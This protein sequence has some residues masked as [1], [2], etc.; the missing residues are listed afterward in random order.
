MR[1]ASGGEDW[2]FQEC[3]A[4]DP[5]YAK[6]DSEK[7]FILWEAKGSSI[8]ISSIANLE[9]D[10]PWV[11][12]TFIINAGS[13]QVR[14][15]FNPFDV[16]GLTINLTWQSAAELEAPQEIE[17][18]AP[19]GDG[20][21]YRIPR[22]STASRSSLAFIPQNLAPFE[23]QPQ[24]TKFEQ[25]RKKDESASD[26]P[27][28]AVEVAQEEW[29]Q[30]NHRRFYTTIGKDLG[31]FCS[32]GGGTLQNPGPLNAQKG[33]L[34]SVKTGVTHVGSRN[35]IFAG[36]QYL[37]ANST[38]AMLRSQVVREIEAKRTFA[39]R[40]HTF[41]T[42][43]EILTVTAKCKSEKGVIRDGFQVR[44]ITG[45]RSDCSYLPAHAIPYSDNVFFKLSQS[46]GGF[47]VNPDV[48]FWR[49]HF[50]IPCGRAKARMLLEFGLIHSSA[51]AQNFIVALQRYG[52]LAGFILRDIG[53]TYWH[54]EMIGHLWGKNHPSAVA[55]AGESG[56]KIQH[57][58]HQTSSSDYPAPHMA[59]LASYSVLTHG[60]AEK[61]I[62]NRNWTYQAV[63]EFG[64]G[65]LDGFR[66][67]CVESFQGCPTPFV[68]RAKDWRTIQNAEILELGKKMA[69]PTKPF[70]T[71]HD[72]ERLLERQ[73]TSAAYVRA[74]SPELLKSQGDKLKAI[75]V[76]LNAEEVLLCAELEAYVASFMPGKLGKTLVL[77]LVCPPEED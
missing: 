50:S 31:A 59:R 38:M 57:T 6:P 61:M 5:S 46:G 62:E 65:I 44:D 37:E 53:D 45:M 55:C 35:Q 64:Q 41:L 13:K 21:L 71:R 14:F 58:L 10:H 36:K 2:C 8:E 1:K 9:R 47:S 34:Y 11:W 48:E 22:W 66:Q 69:Y 60:F 49:E 3:L 56:Q 72:A 24:D 52:E 42:Q 68:P 67:Y 12:S 15:P 20:H 32:S 63:L 18:L 54:G 77:P 25:S 23:V 26:N 51:N 27:F 43:V 74:C 76:I 70:Y 7:D 19:G 29:A 30:R 4:N 17:F 40:D 28:S 16:S 75:Q 33:R 73:P 39:Q